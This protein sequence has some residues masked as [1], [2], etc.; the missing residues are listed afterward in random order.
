[1]EMNGWPEIL[2]LDQIVIQLTVPGD[3]VSKARPR[4][5]GGRF[6][7]PRKTIAYEN[8]VRW[9]FKKELKDREPDKAST[10]GVKAVFYRSTRHRIDIDNMLKSILDAANKLVWE[11]DKQ[12][13]EICARLE[14]ASPDPRVEIII[15]ST[16]PNYPIHIC[17]YCGKA[18]QHYKSRPSKYCSIEC[19]SKSKTVSRI[20]DWCS[21]EFIRPSSV[22]DR[23]GIRFCGSNCRMEYFA[24]QKGS[25]K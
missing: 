5:S 9:H 6:Y 16:K 20:C 2:T 14:L 15:Y 12:V 17:R 13:S 7:T 10:F 18:I 21:K 24:A 1:M 25:A 8:T 23:N 11:D 19:N 4:W 3:P 22:M